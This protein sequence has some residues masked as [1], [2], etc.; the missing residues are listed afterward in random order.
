MLNGLSPR[1]RE[2]LRILAE[3]QDASLAEISAR[4]EVSTVTLRSDL[5]RLADQGYI[6]RTRGGAL[7]AFHPEILEKLKTHV[8]E[9][10]RI[11][12]AAADLIGDGDHIMISAGTT[13]SLIMKYMLGKC[14]VHVVTNSTFLFNFARINPAVHVTL[15]G[16]E[17]RPS[18][19][20]LVGPIALRDLEQFHVKLAFL[21]VDGFS[22]TTGITA[23][24]VD[25]A[26]VVRRMSAQARRSIV[27]AD[28]SKYNWAG[29]AH[30]QNLSAVNTLITDLAL[31]EEVRT[32][33]ESNGIS[34]ITA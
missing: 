34:V 6:V 3:D 15:V 13:S 10:N 23:N 9:K 20:A 4:L 14:D 5:N 18:A 16:G 33:L 25:V 2:I 17:F 11:A 29:F 31:G 8:E 22:L 12:K 19:E 24:F 27:V 26:E 30:I 32:E 1:E 7:P 28:S 21:G